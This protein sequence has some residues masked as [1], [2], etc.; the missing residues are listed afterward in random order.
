MAPKPI[1]MEAMMIS[2]VSLESMKKRA[3]RPAGPAVDGVIRKPLRSPPSTNSGE[4]LTTNRVPS[5]RPDKTSTIR[6]PMFRPVRINRKRAV[7]WAS[8]HEK[9]G[10]LALTDYGGRRDGHQLAF[11]NDNLNPCEHARTQVTSG[12][13]ADFHKKRTAVRIS[14]RCNDVD[15]SPIGACSVPQCVWV[16]SARAVPHGHKPPASV[17]RPDGHLLFQG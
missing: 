5:G 7:F 8:D 12:R 15:N 2:G 3:I 6:S 14:R 16:P 10:Q 17:C 13:Q 1:M 11:T 4:G 9:P